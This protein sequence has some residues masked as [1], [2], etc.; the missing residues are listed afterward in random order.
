MSYQQN[1]AP[2]RRNSGAK[3]PYHK[4][5]NRSNAKSTIHPSKFVNKAVAPAEQAAYVPTHTFSSFGM[6]A[7]TTATLAHLG[8]TNP[9]P[10]QDQCI[11]LA[12]QGRDV[13]GLANTGTG[14]TAAFVLPVIEKTSANRDVVSTLV[15]APTRE[16][17]Q[18]IDADLRRF[19]AGQKIYSTLVVGGAN[20]GQ[21]IRQIQRGPHVVIGTPG[22]VKDLIQRQ[23]CA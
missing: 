11:P 13:I 18:Q 10:I 5:N 15:L 8:F 16:L 20:I 9:T 2:R 22:R 1:G 23:S 17:A 19:A 3:R 21:Q 4:R 14:K 7:K 12:V 6:N